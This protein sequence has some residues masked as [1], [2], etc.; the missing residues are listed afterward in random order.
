MAILDSQ[1][2]ATTKGCDYQ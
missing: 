2:V 1:L